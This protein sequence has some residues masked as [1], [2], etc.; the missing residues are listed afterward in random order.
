MN[1]AQLKAWNCLTEKEQQSLFLRLSENKS[2]WEAGE[3]LGLSH[4]KYIEIRERSE[5]FFKM[6]TEFFEKRSA[7]F[8]PDCPCER[9]FQDFIEGCLEKRLTRKQSIDYC[10]DSTQILS[11]VNTKNIIRNMARLKESED[12]WD[13]DTINLIWEFDRWNNYRIL[14]S[15]WQQPSAYKRRLNKKDKIYIKYLLLRFPEWAHDRLRERFYYKNRYKNTK[16]YWVTLISDK[17]YKDGYKVMPVRPEE[18]IVNE[19]TRFYLYVFDNKEDA[20]TF[21]FLVSTYFI[22]TNEVKLGQKFWPEYRDCVQRA[23]NYNQVNN[24]DFTV[25]QLDSVYKKPIKRKKKSSAS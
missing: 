24:I 11:R 7:I 1:E 21:G 20:D 10:G 4:Y 15:L 8:R 2:T 12:P 13:K 18:D 9:N 19:F 6:F 3:I 14:P 22:K 5:K 25:K 17:R 16:R 23:L